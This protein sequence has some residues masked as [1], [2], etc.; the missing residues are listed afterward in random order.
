MA[1]AHYRELVT[2]KLNKLVV[3]LDG[4][5]VN[6]Y[7]TGTTTPIA[8]SMY[9]TA[10]G[11]AALSNPL[12]SDT[13]GVV[14]FYIEQEQ[15]V[16]L[17]VT[18]TGYTSQTVTVDVLETGMEGYSQ[19]VTVHPTRGDYTT[20]S[21]ALA[22]I[23]DA[24]ASKV[25]SIVVYG[26]ITE[27]S[28]VTA[29]SNIDVVGM[30]GASV[31]VDTATGGSGFSLANLVNT[32]WRNL[33]LKR[34]QAN[35]VWYHSVQISGTSD[36]TV[37]LENCIVQA[38][39][40]GTNIAGLMVSDTSSPVIT[41]CHLKS[42]RHGTLVQQTATPLYQACICEGLDGGT[43][44]HGALVA[45]TAKPIFAGG[46]KLLGGSGGADCYGLGCSD[47]AAPTVIGGHMEGG[48]G[49]NNCYGVYAG[50]VS[51]PVLNGGVAK[52]G[53]GGTGCTAIFSGSGTPEI[54]GTTCINGSG[55]TG[56]RGIDL[57]SGSAAVLKGVK[58]VPPQLSL[59]EE[60]VTATATFTLPAK[61][62]QFSTIMMYVNTAGTGGATLSIGS[63]LGG[64]DIVNAQDITTTGYKYP[65]L[66]AG[67]LVSFAASGTV[68]VTID[69]T[70]SPDVDIYYDVY[71]NYGTCNALR[72]SGNGVVRVDGGQYV[73]GCESDAIYINNPA[74]T[75]NL[76]M[77]AQAYVEAKPKDAGSMKAINCQ[78]AYNPAP[79]YNCTLVGGS[80][81]LTAA[82]GTANGTNVEV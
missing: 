11:G 4:A 72:I 8:A 9:A 50:T 69:G 33:I 14:E 65:T 70:G 10:V 64:T 35:T 59:V 22:A 2:A 28:A 66:G 12:T 21:A 41:N 15:R 55:G 30:G 52:G 61:P 75:A 31:T 32:T 24:S 53:D 60:T 79:V 40:T 77:I 81:N 56:C 3:L 43:E 25:Y 73:S 34:L 17:Y 6:V 27:T 54:H 57:Q 26:Q 63:T 47:M 67:R 48:S 62:C 7:E 80:T 19:V 1:R 29:K 37:R 36:N 42:D 71:V 58:V 46:T 18:K 76:L 78:S 49:G 74:I 39:G 45:D 16:D 23:T 82:A 68:Y 13:S 5:T 44:S 20:L 51:R 38:G